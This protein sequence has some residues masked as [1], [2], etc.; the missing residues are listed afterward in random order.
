MLK[1]GL[2]GGI[3]SGK[4]TITKVF[5]LLNIPVYYADAASKRLYQTNSD[6]KAALKLNFG[7]SI[8]I[9]D[10]LNRAE[11]AKIVFTNPQ[12]LELLNSLVHPLTIKDAEDWM[13]AQNAPYIIKEAALIF[14]SGSHSGLDYVIGVHTPK[15]LRI[16]RVMQRDGVTRQEVINRLKRQIAEEVKMKLCDYIIENGEQ[17]LV[18]PQVLQLHQTFLALS[19][20]GKKV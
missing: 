10:V 17:E 18:I 16:Q 6:L 20:E 5:A 1:I 15:H 7:D 3:G 19:K 9:N 14:E 4:T 8:Y 2:T 12:K 13:N 11:L